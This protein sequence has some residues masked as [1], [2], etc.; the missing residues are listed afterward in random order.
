ML[1]IKVNTVLTVK[2]VFVTA[3]TFHSVFSLHMR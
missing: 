3:I 2:L 1:V